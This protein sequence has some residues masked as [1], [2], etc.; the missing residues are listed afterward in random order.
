MILHGSGLKRLGTALLAAA[1]A[2][3]FSALAMGQGNP[4]VFNNAPT[5]APLPSVC[6]SGVPSIFALGNVMNH[7][8]GTLDLVMICGPNIVTVPGNGDGTFATTSEV[9]TRISSSLGSTITRISLADIDGGPQ[10]DLVAT[11]SSCNVDVFLGTGPGTFS[12]SP[13]Q[14]SEGI[15]PCRIAPGTFLVTDFNGDG[16]PDVAVENALSGVPSIIVLLN[17]STLGAVSFGAP[18]IITLGIPANSADSQLGGMAVGNFTGHTA[19]VV[20][21]LAVAIGTF[22]SGAGTVNLV[23]VLKN[24]GNGTAFAAQQSAALPVTTSTGTLMGLVAANLSGDGFLDLAGVDSGD[25]AIYVLYGHGTG[26]LTT[27]SPSGTTPSIAPCQSTAGQTISGLPLISASHLLSGNFN[28]PSGPP[29]LLFMSANECLSVLLGAA[30]GGLQ[31]AA[32]TYV[33]GNSATSVVAEDVNNDGYTDA[34]AAANTGLNVFLNNTGG[35][36]QGTQAI[37]A[38][39]APGEISLLQNFFGSGEQDVSV[40]SINAGIT[41]GAAVTVL[42]APASGPNG[43]LPQSSGPIP[44]PPGQSITAMTSGCVLAHPGPCTT[45]FVAY[46]TY[47]SATSGL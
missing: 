23:Y 20:A 6:A 13:T 43:T 42:G 4:A 19:P 21:D 26:N 32:K 39:T 38:G 37:I 28:G 16:E 11:D 22:F 27:C 5:I 18:N 29:G 15:S 25:G 9:T 33:V 41:G 3:F 1:P 14:V 45:P 40:V 30:G 7:A 31:T 12:G 24:N 36:L 34:I 35:T 47:K 17:T 2:L 46:A 8:N 44:A 10:L